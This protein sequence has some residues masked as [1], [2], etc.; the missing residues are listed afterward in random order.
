MSQEWKVNAAYR[1]VS[2]F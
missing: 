1:A 2:I